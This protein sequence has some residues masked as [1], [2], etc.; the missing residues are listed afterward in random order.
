MKILLAALTLGAAIALPGAGTAKSLTLTTQMKS[1]SGNNAYLAL[2]VTDSSGKF[3]GTVWV[4]G[5]SSKYHR[6]LLQ[7]YRATGGS[8]AINGITGASVGSGRSLEIQLDLA[9]DMFDAGY[10]LH[11]DA[12][13]QD[14]RESP[15]DVVVPLTTANIG[16]STRGRRY[17]KSFVFK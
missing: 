3:L 14:W 17:V 7:W 12:A 11:I 5:R 1:Y 10:E 9:D 6:H 13:V 16:K 4:S 15:S 8:A 2:Y